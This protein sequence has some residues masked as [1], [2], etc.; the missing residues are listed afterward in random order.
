[1]A[2]KQHIARLNDMVRVEA[3]RNLEVIPLGRST[4]GA[5]CPKGV[6][7]VNKCVSP[8]EAAR[9]SVDVVAPVAV[10]FALGKWLAVEVDVIGRV[11]AGNAL[12]GE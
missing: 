7:A 8:G 2:H 3:S 5:P 1:L 9:A 6:D 4:I 11:A 10:G 12:N